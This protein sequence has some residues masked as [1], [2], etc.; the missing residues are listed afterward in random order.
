MNIA[1]EEIW[2]IVLYGRELRRLND[3]ERKREDGARLSGQKR[4]S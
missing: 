1:E 2:G 3:L 4:R